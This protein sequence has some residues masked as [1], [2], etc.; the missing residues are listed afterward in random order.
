MSSGFG[1]V[2]T[3]PSPRTGEEARPLRADARRN[4]G[5]VL[6]AARA[7]FAEQGLEA[8]MD[9][10][11]RRAGVG[12][13]TV[14]RHYPT[15][16]ALV[17]ALA[18]DH[19][20][21]LAESARAALEEADPWEGFCAFMRRSSE[22]QASDLALVEVMGEQPDA[23]CRAAEQRA[24]LHEAVAELVARAQKAGK[25]RRDVVP[26]DV[27]MLMCGV[28]R[29]TRVG[30]RGPTM[31]WQRYLAIV[32]EGLRAPGSARLPGLTKPAR[33]RSARVPA[34][35]RERSRRAS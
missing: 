2:T 4:R 31:S 22:V 30:S 11:A 27:P 1:S 20:Q 13:G 7:V 35:S 24:D 8:Q 19:F 14:Y 33:V 9:D 29:A 23:M 16:E 12:V 10:I 34:R 26:E 18:D 28:G 17:E 5:L 6:E 32:L 15:K 25:L 3:A 21:R